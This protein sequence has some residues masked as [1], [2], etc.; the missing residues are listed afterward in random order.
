MNGYYT[1]VQGLSMGSK[2]SPALANIFCHMMEFNVINKYINKEVL[3]YIRYVDDVFT[4]LKKG[5]Y[6]N[7]LAEMNSFD[8]DLKF[9]Y[10]KMTK[11]NL[12]FLDTSVYSDTNGILQLKHYKKPSDSGG[13]LNF[14]KSVT[15]IK[16]KLSTLSGEIYRC[17]NTTTTDKNL[18]NALNNLKKRFIKNGY[19]EKMIIK[20][21]TE[22]KNKNFEPSTFKKLRADEMR[23]HPERN[24]NIVLPFTHQRCEKIVKKIIKIVK[25]VTPLFKINF[26]WTNIKLDRFFSPKLKL[27]K[28]ML[29]QNALVYRYCNIYR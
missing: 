1:Q 15:P 6:Q 4:I 20:K 28:P 17:N 19:P 18:D 11:N 26:C 5:C 2:L 29:D 3:F 25:S 27:S 21:I 8:I 24:A 12:V 22:I 9:T 23:D 16:Y 13:V 10:E 14:A 7:I